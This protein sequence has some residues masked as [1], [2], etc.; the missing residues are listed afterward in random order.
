MVREEPLEH[1]PD[2]RKYIAKK[3]E[4]QLQDE[5]DQLEEI[6]KR[7]RQLNSLRKGNATGRKP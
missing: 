5:L 7:K 4:R 6:E 2:L 1:E 3:H